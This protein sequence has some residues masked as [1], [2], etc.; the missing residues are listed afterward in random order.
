MAKKMIPGGAKTS[1]S[2]PSATPVTP[3]NDTEPKKTEDFMSKEEIIKGLIIFFGGAAL[4]LIIFLVAYFSLS[5][6]DINY[7]VSAILA[8][9]MSVV[10]I[11]ALNKAMGDRKSKMQAPIVMVLFIA[12]LLTVLI[13]YQKH[14][15]PFPDS[16]GQGKP[17]SETF[18][19]TGSE[20]WAVHA[21]LHKGQTYKITVSGVSVNFVNGNKWVELAP[22]VNPYLIRVTSDGSPTFDGAIHEAGPRS[23]VTVEWRE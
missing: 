5:F 11:N 19:F 14:G 18:V 9:I 23:T 2:A 3:A 16:V 17:K 7:L 12:F 1:V 8:I 21:K 6:F 10:I 4:G 13:G 22:S 15:S 20:R